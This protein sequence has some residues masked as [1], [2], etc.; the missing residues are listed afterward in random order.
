MPWTLSCTGWRGL[1]IS[2]GSSAT[3]AT[4]FG[5][6]GAGTLTPTP[7]RPS[8]WSSTPTPT[9]TPRPGI[10]APVWSMPSPGG[11]LPSSC[12]RSG[13]QGRG[14]LRKKWCGELPPR[15]SPVWPGRN[16]GGRPK[17]GW[18][19]RDPRPC[20]IEAPPGGLL[21]LR[22]GAQGWRQGGRRPSGRQ[23]VEGSPE[24]R[25][26]TVRRMPSGGMLRRV[27][28][29]GPW[30]R[31]REPG[32]SRA[33]RPPRRCVPRA[34]GQIPPGCSRSSPRRRGDPAAA[35]RLGR[36]SPGCLPVPPA[37]PP[38]RPGRSWSGGPPPEE[39]LPLPAPGAAPLRRPRR[40]PPA[41]GPQGV[42]RRRLRRFLR[43]GPAAGVDPEDPGGHE[44]GDEGE[45]AAQRA[46][47]AV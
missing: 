12:S 5:P 15:A 14:V 9:T 47:G 35:A 17:G 6:I 10:G 38:P 16:S 11:G 32:R 25:A 36:S 43:G 31:F 24:V 39:A 46:S 44:A 37:P 8:V 42:E 30:G 29:R 41:V 33:V 21:S 28:R 1:T 13:R 20:R 3:T 19:S 45:A 4:A 40:P 2:P 7:A 27:R 34:E 22:G 26:R 18:R 23:G